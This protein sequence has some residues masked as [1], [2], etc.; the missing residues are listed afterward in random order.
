MKSKI[1]RLIK[2]DFD[3][4]LPNIILSQNEINIKTQA[5]NI[6]EGGFSVSNSRNTTMKGLVYSSN[7]ALYIITD[8]FKGKDNHISFNIDTK[9]LHQGDRI[10]GKISIISDC[11]EI[12]IPYNINIEAPYFET[13]LFKVNDLKKFAH[14]AKIDWLEAKTIFKSEE[15]SKVILKNNQNHISLYENLIK[16][17][18]NSNALEEFLISTGFKSPINISVKEI[19]N[20]VIYENEN[21]YYKI[22]LKTNNWGY[23]KISLSASDSFINLSKKTIWLDEFNNNTYEFVYKLDINKMRKGNNFGR[24]YINTSKQRLSLDITCRIPHEKSKFKLKDKEDKNKFII[25]YLDFR[26]GKITLAQFVSALN[27]MTD[28]KVRDS[29]KSSRY[30]ILKAYAYII[31]NNNNAEFHLNKLQLK[32]DQ[33]KQ[34]SIIEHGLFL[35]LKALYHKDSKSIDNAKDK[36]ER[37]YRSNYSWQLLWCLF[38]LDNNY[39]DNNKNKLNKIIDEFNIGTT[40]PILYYE[41]LSIYNSNPSY[42]MELSKFNIQI[43]NFAIKYDYLNL[44]LS[45]QFIYLASKEKRFNKII[46]TCL[47]RLYEKYGTNEILAAI[48]STAIK[49]HKRSY[50]YFKYYELGIENQLR[51]TEIYE[52]YLYTINNDMSKILPSSILN[53]F[54]YSSNLYDSKKAYL[55]SNIIKNRLIYQQLYS[56]DYYESYIKKI[57]TFIYQIIAARKLDF[58]IG[59]LYNIFFDSIKDINNYISLVPHIVFKHR[60][61]CKEDNV[62]AIKVVHLEMNKEQYIALEDYCAYIDIYTDNYKIYFIDDEGNQFCDSI[63]YE[64]V[65]IINSEKY[66]DKLILDSQF[67]QVVLHKLSKE[68]AKKENSNKTKLSDELRILIKTA[69]NIKDIDEKYYNQLIVLLMYDTEKLDDLEDK[70]LE[71]LIKQIDFN[72]LNRNDRERLIEYYINSE[73]YEL[74]INKIKEYGYSGLNNDLLTNLLKNTYSNS[75][76]FNVY[77]LINEKEINEILNEI[78]IYLFE[79]GITDSFVLE[80]LLE[81]Y[82]GPTITMYDI[83]KTSRYKVNNLFLMEERLICQTL[84][85]SSYRQED[86]EVFQS[87]LNNNDIEKNL[88]LIKA[89]L[90]YYSFL[91]LRNK[92]N[93]SSD[94]FEYIKGMINYYNNKVCTLSYL[95]NLSLSQLD[96]LTEDELAFIDYNINKMYDEGIIMPFYKRFNNVIKLPGDIIDKQ[97]IQYISSPHNKVFIHYRLNDNEIINEQMEDII[98]GLHI[99]EIR[100]FYGEELTYYFTENNDDQLTSSKIYKLSIANDLIE[101]KS[102]YSQLNNMLKTME[103]NKQDQ[104]KELMK[105]YAKEK[106]IISKLIKPL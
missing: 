100:L 44:D 32:E 72:L 71:T 86:I 98:A 3:Y 90:S 53:Y 61:T 17:A 58:N 5:D 79:K 16:N 80:Y 47:E 10:I 11:G 103:N 102:K 25:K 94:L 50:K 54:I 2:E 74:A 48:C 104:L 18:S 51:I 15:F 57:E 83:W 56:C 20:D 49:G 64:L 77:N 14:L 39:K 22:K 42:L 21:K 4:E 85:V 55:Y 91:Y 35:Y 31:S 7:P 70:N 93:I 37:Y 59:N 62:K 73:L 19:T 78:S 81:K 99:K 13:S 23:E 89:F 65:K 63:Q 101:R 96:N 27:I 75:K 43:I 8:A 46:F 68:S 95:K 60:I 30:E 9:N 1:E 92:I 41:A 45:R 82:N 40:S 36:I 105:E 84:Y 12:S 88:N 28:D 67:E 69:I 106:Y 52:Y 97:F 38:Y 24:I 87:Y 76:K 34:Y 29:E 33:I 6:I 26:M 66:I